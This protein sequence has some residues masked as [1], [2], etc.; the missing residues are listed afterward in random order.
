MLEIT[1]EISQP[2]SFLSRYRVAFIINNKVTLTYGNNDGKTEPKTGIKRNGLGNSR[3]CHI[4][5]DPA[6]IRA[7]G[8]GIIWLQNAKVEVIGG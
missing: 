7:P 6:K 8:I 5:I 2:D 3:A 4:V 1:N